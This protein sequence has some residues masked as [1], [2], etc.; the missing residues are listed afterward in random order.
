MPREPRVRRELPRTVFDTL[1]AARSR[2]HPYRYT[3]RD[4]AAIARFVSRPVEFDQYEVD[5]RH[6][7]RTVASI[8]P[9]REQV[10]TQ[11]AIDQRIHAQRR[12]D[13]D[14]RREHAQRNAP[15]NALLARLSDAPPS[16]EPIV[17]RPVLIDF[18]RTTDD[19][20]VKIF[21]PKI[22]ATRR[23]LIAVVEVLDEDTISICTGSAV[24]RILDKRLEKLLEYCRNDKDRL[25]GVTPAEWQGLNWGLREIGKV[26][27]KALRANLEPVVERITEIAHG[28]YFSFIDRI[29]FTSV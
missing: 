7:Q 14:N 25:V 17:T 19:D 22:E 5:V 4:V 28:G 27:F 10:A 18:T 6:L 9:R 21:I 24:V 16:H 8:P 29:L 1:D 26:S 13:D 12:A 2:G 15:R 11:N 3:E 20:R 23:R